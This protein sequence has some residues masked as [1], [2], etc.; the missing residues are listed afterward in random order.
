MLI[1]KPHTLSVCLLFLITVFAADAL[2]YSIKQASAV[3]CPE[4][5]FA[6]AIPH[7]KAISKVK[8]R[9]IMKVRPL[10]GE[11]MRTSSARLGRVPCCL[12][13]PKTRGW[14]MSGE[15]IFARTKGKIRFNRGQYWGGWYGNRSPDLDLNSN[16]GLPDHNP[17]ASMAVAYRFRPNWSVRYSLMPMELTGSGGELL[18][19]AYYGQGLGVK[20]QRLYHRVGLAYD[21]V[22]TYRAR[23]SIFG[24]YVRVDE[25]ISGIR[26]ACATCP[27]GAGDTYDHS[28]NMGM[29]GLE[30]ERCLKATRW[31]KY[32]S[33]ECRAGIA[34][35][36][37]A[38]GSDIATGLKCTI[39]MGKGRWGYVGG[40]YRFVTFKKGYSDVEQIDTA[41][42]GGYLKMG[43]IF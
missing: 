27:I 23:I 14:E 21:P 29:A 36:D 11:W 38:F 25:K 5:L 22:R 20:W 18:N 1:R 6:P 9:P 13:K 31:G 41:I 7:Y 3:N 28:L 40:G 10:R 4:D 15:V 35:L 32:L 2:G 12:P 8:P 43:I 30:F 37:K 26:G 34:F 33:C 19:Q 24:D 17:V 39:P 42:E 16:L